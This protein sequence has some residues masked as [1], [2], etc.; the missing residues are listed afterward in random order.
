MI[1]DRLWLGKPVKNTLRAR[2]RPPAFGDDFINCSRGQ[3]RAT[4]QLAGSLGVTD[5]PPADA[6]RTGAAC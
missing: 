2:A 3:K 4:A 1:Y 6:E 5:M